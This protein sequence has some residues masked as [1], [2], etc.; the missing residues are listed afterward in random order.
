MRKIWSGYYSKYIGNNFYHS[1]SNLRTGQVLI[2]IIVGLFIFLLIPILLSFSIVIA[3]M[4]SFEALTSLLSVIFLAATITTL[5]LAIPEVFKRFFSARDVQFLFTMPIPTQSIIWVKYIRSFIQSAGI[6]WGFIIIIC[7]GFGV[8]IGASWLYFMIVP[9][10]TLNVVMIGMAFA[11]V[12]NIGLIQFLPRN[13]TKELVTI[14]VGT[15]GLFIYFLFQLPNLIRWYHSLENIHFHIPHFLTWLPIGWG[16]Q[17]ISLAA[18]GSLSSLGWTIIMTIFSVFVSV[19]AIAFVERGFRVGWIR[20]NEGGSR[21]KYKI[22]R[23][24]T[25]L[26]HTVFVL[27][28]KEWRAIQRDPREWMIFLPLL[29]ILIIPVFSL[30][31]NRE[32][33]QMVLENTLLSWFIVQVTLVFVFSIVTGSFSASSIGREGRAVWILRSTPLTGKQIAIGKLWIHWLVPF[34]FVIIMEAGFC[35]LLGWPL[36]LTIIGIITFGII[37]LGICSIGLWG[38]TLGAQYNPDN[39]QNHLQTG[40]AFLMILF[41]LPYLMIISIPA[42]LILIPKEYDAFFYD[43]SEHAGGNF[44]LAATTIGNIITLKHSYEVLMIL[45]GFTILIGVSLLTTCYFLNLTA[46]RIDSGI[47]VKFIEGN[48]KRH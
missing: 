6:I 25:V 20:V 28:L 5:F 42:L 16:A 13:R 39:L 41:N 26:K 1:L 7:I 34:L 2:I 17:A 35:I 14:M 46:K 33:I 18:R 45:I 31:S 27:G 24:S 44:S 12:V 8:A 29:I 9:I 32:M 21:K 3:T 19:L 23:G 22:P 47:Q 37:S 30:I 36:S 40:I 4:L 10:V 15:T 48:S 11:Y 43:L 38:G